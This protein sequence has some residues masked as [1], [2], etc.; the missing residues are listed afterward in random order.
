MFSKMKDLLKD[1]LSLDLNDIRYSYYRLSSGIV[2]STILLIMLC[3]R[4]FKTEGYLESTYNSYSL[5]NRIKLYTGHSKTSKQILWD[6]MKSFVGTSYFHG[7]YH[8]FE[9]SFGTIGKFYNSDLYEKT[10]GMKNLFPKFLEIYKKNTDQLEN[11][12]PRTFE[13]IRNIRNSVHNNGV[14]IPD[15]TNIIEP[16][17][18]DKGKV[19]FSPYQTIT[20]D[21]MWEVNLKMSLWCFNVITGIITVPEIKAEPSILDPSI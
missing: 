15:K 14:F 17:N 9:H 11:V 2:D 12:D 21:D 16:L 18:F 8:T 13:Y 1:D 19:K 10:R 4:G 5:N 6:N 20:V 3:D 7:I